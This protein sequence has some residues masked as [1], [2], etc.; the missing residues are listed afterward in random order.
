MVT[1]TCLSQDARMT[2]TA[3]CPDAISVAR[4]GRAAKASALTE[5]RLAMILED[6]PLEV[7]PSDVCLRRIAMDEV[8]APA[9]KEL[10]DGRCTCRTLKVKMSVSSARLTERVACSS[11]VKRTVPASFRAATSARPYVGSVRATSSPL[12]M[13]ARHISPGA[14]MLS[15]SVLRGARIACEKVMSKSTMPPTESRRPLII[16]VGVGIEMSRIATPLTLRTGGMPSRMLDTPE[17]LRWFTGMYCA[18]GP[19]AT[20]VARE[21]ITSDRSPASPEVVGVGMR[22]KRAAGAPAGMLPPGI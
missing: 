21:G 1:L 22:K 6:A 15:A 14:P 19:P 20:A 13:R 9:L 4:V 18:A 16:M 10:W 12:K 17:A 8:L 2:E 5:L 11:Q 7:D 3:H